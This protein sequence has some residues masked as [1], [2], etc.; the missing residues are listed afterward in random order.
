MASTYTP[1]GVEL[2]ATGENAGTWGTKTNT[3]LQNRH[4]FNLFQWHSSSSFFKVPFTKS[5]NLQEDNMNYIHVAMACYSEKMS[6]DHL[7]CITSFHHKHEIAS[8][9]DITS[10]HRQ[11]AIT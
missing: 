5:I 11:H 10:F 1:L 4:L 2:M 8:D 7:N 9:H 3:N 6:A